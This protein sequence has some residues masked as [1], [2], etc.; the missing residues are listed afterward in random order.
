ML[1]SE[2]PDKEIDTTTVRRLA[3]EADVD[4]RTIV[5]ELKAARGERAR[6]RGISGDRAR[7]VLRQHGFLP[8]GGG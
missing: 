8:S 5:A 6:V 2:T 1:H 3:L 4:P 7:R